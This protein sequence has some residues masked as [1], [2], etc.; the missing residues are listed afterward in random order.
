MKEERLLTNCE[1]IPSLSGKFSEIFC[2]KKMFFFDI[3]T[4]CN[5]F[6]NQDN[7][8]WVQSKIP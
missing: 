2:E 4:N 7:Q 6:G 3:S 1:S 8:K 5:N